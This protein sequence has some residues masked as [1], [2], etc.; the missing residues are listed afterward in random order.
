MRKMQ[1]PAYWPVFEGL[2]LS[3]NNTVSLDEKKVDIIKGMVVVVETEGE[4]VV[5]LEGGGD[6]SIMQ[7]K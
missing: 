7:L 6:I 1:M 2:N 3:E 5:E 4:L